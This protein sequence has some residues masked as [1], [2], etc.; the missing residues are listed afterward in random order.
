MRAGGGGGDGRMPMLT[1]EWKAR[2]LTALKPRMDW[3]DAKC[4]DGFLRRSDDCCW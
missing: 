1:L 2:Q 4:D 3:G